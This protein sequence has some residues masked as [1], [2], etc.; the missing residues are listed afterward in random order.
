MAKIFFDWSVKNEEEAYEKNIEMA[1][2]NE[3]ITGNLLD[4]DYF[5]ESYRLIAIDLCKQTKLIDFI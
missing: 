4:I 5:K 1:R 3:Y 2:N